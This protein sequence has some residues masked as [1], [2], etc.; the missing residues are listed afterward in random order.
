MYGD[1]RTSGPVTQIL[2]KSF[3]AA[4]DG[5]S[6]RYLRHCS[7]IRLHYTNPDLASKVPGLF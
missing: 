1:V 6:Y 5:G 2:G 3:L 4:I 7:L